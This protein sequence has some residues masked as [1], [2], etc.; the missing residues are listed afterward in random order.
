MKVTYDPTVD[1]LY[2]ELSDA[3]QVHGEAAEGDEATVL[4]YDEKERVV[5]IEVLGASERIVRDRLQQV[6]LH[7]Y[8]DQR[9]ASTT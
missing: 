8:A 6:N 9:H 5:A 2:I 7:V 4:H 1:V 3:A